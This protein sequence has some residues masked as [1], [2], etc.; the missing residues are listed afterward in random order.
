MEEKRRLRNEIAQSKDAEKTLGQTEASLEKKPSAKARD[1]IKNPVGVL[2][3]DETRLQRWGLECM[4]AGRGALPLLHIARYLEDCPSPEF[5]AECRRAI[6][7]A[8]GELVAF[9]IIPQRK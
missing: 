4:G 5:A 8:N 3:Y 1:A 6:R 9:P 2:N 7:E